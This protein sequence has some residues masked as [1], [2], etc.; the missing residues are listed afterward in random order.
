MLVFNTVWKLVSELK[1]FGVCV[2]FRAEIW[3]LHARVA[4]RSAGISSMEVSLA[5][6]PLIVQNIHQ[7]LLARNAVEVRAFSGITSDYQQCL[8]QLRDLRV[9]QNVVCNCKGACVVVVSCRGV[10]PDHLLSHRCGTHSLTK[11]QL[12]SDE[13][14]SNFQK[15]PMQRAKAWPTAKRQVTCDILFVCNHG[16]TQG[17]KGTI[18]CLNPSSHDAA[19][20]GMCF[21]HGLL[22]VDACNDIEIISSEHESDVQ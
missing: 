14:T 16:D 13:K 9:R 10:L 12:S 5:V 18:P 22:I 1:R 20:I 8:R 3:S 17:S 7:Q 4:A 6:D 11:K 19:C 2:S 21:G 15:Q